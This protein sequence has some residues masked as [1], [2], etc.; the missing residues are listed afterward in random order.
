MRK[1]FYLEGMLEENGFIPKWS[2]TCI[3]FCEFEGI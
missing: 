3:E 1:E 2:K